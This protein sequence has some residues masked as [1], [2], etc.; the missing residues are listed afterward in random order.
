MSA[1]S[2]PRRVSLAS[3]LFLVLAAAGEA[4]SRSGLMDVQLL[5]SPSA[6][7]VAF[8]DGFT[9]GLFA[10]H[11]GSTLS[12]LAYGLSLAILIGVPL[13][14]AI[15]LSRSLRGVVWPIVLVL[16]P[17]PVSVLIPLAIAVFGFSTSLYAALV[18]LTAG[19]PMVMAAADS[20]K[21][22]SP[23][24]LET[25]RTLGVRAYRIP[26][27]IVLPAALPGLIHGIF[28]AVSLGVVV[29]VTCEILVS[30]QGIGHLIILAQRS[31]RLPDMYAAVTLVGAFGAFVTYSARLPLRLVKPR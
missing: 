15:G 19:I 30:S 18:A 22:V 16:Y 5:P 28:V 1:S 12:R 13:G 24:L 25:G 21:R 14:V 9:S 31:Y 7:A 10:Q 3:V 27:H 26:M 29:L 6:V 23:V 8:A 17:V 20:V 2:L 11:I 4:A